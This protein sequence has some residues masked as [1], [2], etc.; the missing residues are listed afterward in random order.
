MTKFK[1]NLVAVA[2]SLSVLAGTARPA[3]ADILDDIK[4]KVNTCVT[5][6]IEARDRAKEARDKA[7]EIRLAVQAGIK[8]LTT[9]VRDVIAE[10]VDEAKAMI[11]EELEGRDAFVNGGEGET[12]R[13]DLITLLTEFE[14]LLD[15]LATV[16]PDATPKV[17]FES[18]IG[19]IDKAPLAVLWPLYR[20]LSTVDFLDAGLINRLKDTNAALEVAIPV[21]RGDGDGASSR[22]T[23][24]A[25]GV[26]RAATAAGVLRV[27][28]VTLQLAG[29][30]VQATNKMLPKAFSRKILAI[31]G[32]A[33]ITIE[34]GDRLEGFGIILE[35]VGIL[36]GAIGEGAQARLDE[37]DSLAMQ[38]AIQRIEDDQDAILANQEEILANQDKILEALT[39]S[40]GRRGK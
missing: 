31:H 37:A 40:P 23:V 1:T 35:T 34:P 14:T 7:E 28:S 3:R 5:R 10:G 26:S 12:F 27:T 9:T 2:V 18:E 25:G 20:I 6:A 8:N 32:Y 29:K 38:D 13:T 16:D 30:S 17:S 39:T 22:A 4:A 33:G 15:M 19:I 36:V 11:D 24:G 21:F